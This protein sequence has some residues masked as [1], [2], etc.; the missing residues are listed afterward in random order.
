[1]ESVG[2]LTLKLLA[3]SSSP[4]LCSLYRGSEDSRGLDKHL[5]EI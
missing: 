4:A 2:Y 1:M 5:L 3:G